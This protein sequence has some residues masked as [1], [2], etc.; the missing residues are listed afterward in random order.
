MLK[1]LLI[2]GLLF[3]TSPALLAQSLQTQYHNSGAEVHV[4]KAHVADA[5]LTVVVRYQN[6]T[7]AKIEENYPV[8]EVYYIDPAEN[9]KYSVLKDENGKWIANPV[10]N[11]GLIGTVGRDWGL[12]IEA[13]SASVLW[14]KFP[15]P[16]SGHDTVNLVIPNITPFDGLPVSR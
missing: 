1:R 5:V 9:K 3:F 2:A 7:G 12:E 8:A 15:A 13:G 14:F 4:L 6:T 10:N 11:H 16:A